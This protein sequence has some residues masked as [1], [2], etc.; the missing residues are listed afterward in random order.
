MYVQQ[1]CQ[2]PSHFLSAQMAVLSSSFSVFIVLGVY[3]FGILH[4]CA[5]AVQ[6]GDI[7]VMLWAESDSTWVRVKLSNDIR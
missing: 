2:K 6:G 3:D 7:R 4:H 5:M 1:V